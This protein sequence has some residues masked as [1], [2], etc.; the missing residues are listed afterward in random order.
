MTNKFAQ[1]H[2]TWDGS[3]N[4]RDLG[5]Y[6]TATG[7]VIRNRALMRSDNLGHLTTT[8]QQALIDYGIRTI[9]DV[10]SRYEATTWPHAFTQHN[11][12][13]YRN[14]PLGEVSNVAIKAQMENAT[15]IEWNCLALD[16]G[17]EQVATILRTLSQAEP[18][19][20]LIHCHAGKDRTGLV[21]ALILA[22]LGVELE[23]IARDYAASDHYLQPLYA[24]W[25]QKVAD[26]PVKHAE[27]AEQLTSSPATM[28]G[29]FAHLDA[30][31]DGVAGYTQRCGITASEIGMITNRLCS[32]AVHS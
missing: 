26:D 20:V 22:L 23:V 1:Q 5:G 7:M 24:E 18:G 15:L 4:A 25:L 16:H 6:P 10:R 28:R 14:I 11:S 19:G 9:I 21:V 17:Q 31:Y 30:N 8:G 12:L 29:I 3:Y 27:L 2:L 32:E 13:V